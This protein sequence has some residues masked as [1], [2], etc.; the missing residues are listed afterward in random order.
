MLLTFMVVGQ[1]VFDRKVDFKA[2]DIP[3]ADALISLCNKADI[4]VSFDS[5]LFE[6]APTVSLQHQNKSLKFL[7][8][9][10]LKE[11]EIG[12]NW[13]D[14]R[15][16]LYQKPPPI[17]TISGFVEDSLSGERLVSATVFDY[18]S[19][20][21]TT[22][23][24]YGFYSLSIPRGKASLGFSYL[25]FNSCTYQIN[26]RKNL[27]FNVP[28]KSSVTLEEIIVTDDRIS[29]KEGLSVTDAP[30]Y[31]MDELRKIPATGGE[32][33]VLK[34][35][36]TLP[37]VEAGSGSLGGTHVRGGDANHNLILL[38][39]VPVYSPSHSLGLFSIFNENIVK[40]AKIY[41]GKFPAKYGGRL[42]SVIDI[43]TKEGNDKKFKFG[44]GTSLF[45]SNATVEG[46]IKKDKTSFLLSGRRTQL[47]PLISLISIT[48]I[49]DTVSTEGSL[50]Y[51]F[52]DFNA[53]I[54]HT[55]SDKDK[56]Y[57]SFYRG[58]DKF[59]FVNYN[60]EVI[61][62]E[63]GLEEEE[64]EEEENSTYEIT[65]QGDFLSI[66]W[67]NTILSSRWNRMWNNKLFSNLTLTYS[68]FVFRFLNSTSRDF[69]FNERELSRFE[70]FDFS[71]RIQDVALKM[72]FDFVKNNNHYLKFGIGLKER[73]FAPNFEYNEFQVDGNAI[74][75]EE[76]LVPLAS[77]DNHYFA[78]EFNFYAEDDWTI[79]DKLS[80]QFGFHNALFTA[81]NAAWNAFQPRLSI[82][83]DWLPF[84]KIYASYNQMSQ[85]LH[86]LS[87]VG[88][89][90]PF[91]LWVP[92]TKEV[93]PEH[94]RQILLG[95]EW[96]LPADFI[97]GAE[98]YYKKLDNLIT[99]RQ[100]VNDF[101][102]SENSDFDWE[103]EITTG[104]GWNYG[105]ETSLA[106][107]KGKATG[108]INYTWSKAE[109]QFEGLSN[110]ERFPFRF[111]RAHVFKV[112]LN[113]EF[114][115]KFNFNA[116]WY[117]GSG[118]Y[119]TP[120]VIEIIGEGDNLD[121]FQ[122]GF[123]NDADELNNVKLLPHH[124]L[125]VSFNF[126]WP[127]KRIEHFFTF[128]INNFYNNRNPIF[129]VREQEIDNP[130]NF[131]QKDV[132]GLPFMPGLR[133]AIKF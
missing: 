110:N 16:V 124:Q 122:F 18:I 113:Q 3:V 48:E 89:S 42:A 46:P 80:A 103:K 19:G 92:S 75:F 133:Y 1:S 63:L 37:G 76:Q 57:V 99:Y 21:G 5:R 114:G 15:L 120:R 62:Y 126:H 53:K 22:T 128:S 125:D 104:Q 98:L 131:V 10:C 74:P 90:M 84:S 107:K 47:E 121:A 49:N 60:Y 34:F 117:Y 52:Y 29:L 97:F 20:K 132:P 39:G 43:Q 119:T 85:F 28:L 116:A 81:S 4:N 96:R 27:Y 69:D 6:N 13:K 95:T 100:E 65:G 56:L 7:L 112:G 83:Y 26:I 127:R 50:G 58:S 72:D 70:Q 123:N 73:R 44:V 79:T 109:R 86:V 106:R 40:S 12:F 24:E 11:T 77:S 25:G 91:D 101:F 82:Q 36:Q 30:N 105:V 67:G 8:T 129:S 32:P 111:N 31:A 14:N 118:Q 2:E 108:Y 66:N 41:K 115:P 102:M 78:T 130:G 61:P 87:P 51:F 88:I 33:D 64:E 93:A 17:Y 54:N 38:D 59:K 71:S 45:A 94:A 55:L 9:A 68:E 35:F 23:N